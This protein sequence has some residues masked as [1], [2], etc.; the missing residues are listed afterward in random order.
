MRVEQ[1]YLPTSACQCTNFLAVNIFIQPVVANL[2][3]PQFY[4]S[5]VGTRSFSVAGPMVWKSVRDSSGDLAVE[6]E[7]FVRD[8]Q[9]LEIT[10]VSALE[11]SQFHRFVLHT[12]HLLTDIVMSGGSQQQ[13]EHEL[14][15]WEQ[16]RS[17]EQLSYVAEWW[18]EIL[19]LTFC[20]HAPTP[21][22]GLS[23]CVVSRYS[24]R[25]LVV[26]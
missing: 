23:N 19:Q 9:M 22:S 2:N 15:V 11:L 6:F 26:L 5:A 24:K 7:W 25:R 4:C 21:F 1:R 10:D 12:W 17:C 16:E 18:A 3:I 13:V 20:W 8:F 14:K